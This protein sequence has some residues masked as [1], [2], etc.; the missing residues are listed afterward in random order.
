M[1]AGY[2]NGDPAPD[3]MSTVVIAAGTWAVFECTLQTL[4]DTNT[5][6]WKEWLPGN[7]A[8]DVSGP[9]NIEWYSPEGDF[10]P[11]QKCEIWIPVVKKAD[12]K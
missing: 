2:D 11:G 12:A 3:L 6:I 10:G 4:Q 9:Y 5:R 1:I 8:Y 7:S